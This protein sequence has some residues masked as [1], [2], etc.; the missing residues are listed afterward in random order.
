MTQCVFFCQGFSLL[1]VA[2]TEIRLIPE[3]CNCSIVGYAVAQLVEAICYKLEGRFFG[4]QWGHCIFSFNLPNPS[5]RTITLRLTQPL[6]VM[7]TRNFSGRKARPACKLT[8]SLLSLIRL[9]IICS[10]LD[11]SQP[12]RPPRAVA[13]IA[14]L[15]TFFCSI[16][17]GDYVE[18]AP[19]VA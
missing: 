16:V 18:D 6:T 15:F 14:L 19:D 1:V 17:L 8:T 4:S 12:Y 11:V 10:I 7:R 9:S 3:K 2:G 13:E 5:S